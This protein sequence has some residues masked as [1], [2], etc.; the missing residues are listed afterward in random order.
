M[1]DLANYKFPGKLGNNSTKGLVYNNVS[2]FNLVARQ[3]YTG[4]ENIENSEIFNHPNLK[5]FEEFKNQWW[6]IYQEPYHT[7]ISRLQHL[8]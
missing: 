8:T 2:G 4:Y 7:L 5:I 6:G 3:K 1:K